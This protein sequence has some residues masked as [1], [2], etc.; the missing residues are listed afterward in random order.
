MER[1]EKDAKNLLK[2]MD[3]VMGDSI[4]EKDLIGVAIKSYTKMA[5][6]EEIGIVKKMHEV[7]VKAL[8]AYQGEEESV[9]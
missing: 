2:L 8:K 3:T 9:I 5:E 1:T 6:V 7:I 4:T